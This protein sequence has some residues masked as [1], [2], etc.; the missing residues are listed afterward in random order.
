MEISWQLYLYITW[1]WIAVGVITFFYLLRTTAPYG[2]HTTEKWGPMISNQWGWFLMEFFVLTV[3]YFFIFTG[4]RQ[5]N[6]VTGIFAGLFN[7]HYI[8]RSIIFPLR[9]KTPGKKMPMVIMFSGMTFNLMNGFLIGYFL[10]NFADYPLSWLWDPRFIAGT[11]LFVS[12]MV[13]NWMADGKL[14]ALRKPGETGYKIPRGWLFEKISCPNLF[15]ETIE[16]AGFA[17][18]TWSWPG[19]TFFVWT[20]A[21]L[22]PRAISHHKW[23]KQKFPDYPANRKVVFPYIL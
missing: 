14:I 17:L 12:G 2:R 16:W 23:Y 15:G 8:N 5:L 11:I 22:V 13:I 3:L 4:T 6:M 10:G 21:N 19:L 1:A 9:L 20:F 18:L 7:F